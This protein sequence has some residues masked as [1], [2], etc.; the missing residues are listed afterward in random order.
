MKK[1]IRPSSLP[2][3][4][5]CPQYAP[6]DRERDYKDDGT[7]R[8]KVLAA[9]VLNRQDV[10][11]R[12]LPSVEKAL[13]RLDQES[14]EGITWA[15]EYID[16]HKVGNVRSEVRVDVAAGKPGEGFGGTCDF[17]D[18]LDKGTRNLFDFKWREGKDYSAQ[19]T[20]YALG[21]MQE[22]FTDKVRVHI[23]FGESKRQY[24]FYVTLEEAE[25]RVNGIIEKV[26][27]GAPAN[28]CSYCSWCG[29]AASCQ[30][31][32]DRANA[33]AAGR[34]DWGLEQY[35]STEIND[36]EEA[37]KARKLALHLEKW[38]EAVKYHTLKLAKQH[39]GLP[40]FQLNTKQGTRFVKSI[41]DACARSG[42]TPD[43]FLGA[44]KVTLGEL[45]RIFAT[46]FELEYTSKAAAL[47]GLAEKL[48]DCI[49]RGE[50]TQVLKEIKEKKKGGK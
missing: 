50:S 31:L 21:I 37:A 34:E 35:H 19:L 32:A 29:N 30:A 41:P 15:A 23:L 43:Q 20:A 39:G 33:V 4:E 2:A 17:R 26:E 8:H 47:R 45:E 5:V 16:L 22:D 13:E 48:G 24:S 12:K 9:L 46:E 10:D 25:E 49:D 3:L 42:L 36:P 18:G 6:D 11:P 27:T 7:R 38:V 14:R 28:P 44:C 40:G 1:T